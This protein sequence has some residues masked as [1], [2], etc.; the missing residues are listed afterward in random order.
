MVE[1]NKEGGGECSPQPD[2]YPVEMN[3]SL[4][5]KTGVRQLTNQNIAPASV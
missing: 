1:E 4:V 5:D 2:I 3:K